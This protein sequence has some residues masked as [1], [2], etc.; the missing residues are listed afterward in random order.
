MKHN[1]YELKEGEE[2]VLDASFRNSSIVTILA[3]TKPKQMFATVRSRMGGEWDVM[4]RRLT[5]I[6]KT[7]EA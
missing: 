3:F 2:A 4:T 5:K 6:E 7:T 1:K